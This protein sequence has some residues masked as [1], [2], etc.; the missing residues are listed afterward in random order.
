MVEAHREEQRIAEEKLRLQK[1]FFDQNIRILQTHI[2]E[3]KKEI[4]VLEEDVWG[5][6][7]AKKTVQGELIETRQEFDKF[8][9]RVR[10]FNETEASFLLPEM[11]TVTLT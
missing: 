5:V 11:K 4:A 10:P 9:N 3:H 7:Q 2:V 8:I 1:D 6:M